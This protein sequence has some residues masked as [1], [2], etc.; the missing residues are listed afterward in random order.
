MSWRSLLSLVPLASL[1]VTAAG[2]SAEG[3]LP[4]FY[5]G[6]EI[7]A[8]V[9][10]PETGRPIEGAMIVA[11]WALETMSGKEPIQVSEVLS[12]AKGEFVTPG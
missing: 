5:S 9:V 8:T 3:I 12:D 1:V 4:P 2:E 10:D 6:K 7:R 11:V